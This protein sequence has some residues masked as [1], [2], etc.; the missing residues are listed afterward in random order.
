LATANAFDAKVQSDASAIS[1]QYAAIAALAVRQAFGATELTIS[2][3]SDG[4]WNTTD[5]MMFIKGIFGLPLQF[6]ILIFF[7]VQKSPVMG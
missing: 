4:S 2:K 7:F 3:A 1:G 5:I 6:C